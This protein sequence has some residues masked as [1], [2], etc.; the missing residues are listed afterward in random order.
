MDEKENNEKVREKEKLLLVK[1]LLIQIYENY[2]K[3]DGLFFKQI[4]IDTQF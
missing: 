4:K 3:Q 1:W 2:F